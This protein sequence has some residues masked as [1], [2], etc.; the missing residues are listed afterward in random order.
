[1]KANVETS[2]PGTLMCI[3]CFHARKYS[4]NNEIEINIKI[5]M[6]YGMVRQLCL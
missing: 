6:K 4:V 5:Y 2:S 3:R 1:M